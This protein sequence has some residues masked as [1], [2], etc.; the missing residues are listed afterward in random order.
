MKAIKSFVLVALLVCFGLLACSCSAKGG[1]GYDGYAPGGAYGDYEGVP[2]AGDGTV[3]EPNGGLP[4]GSMTAGAWNDNDNYDLWKQLF[5]QGQTEEE[6]GKFNGISQRYGFDNSERVSVT[7]KNGEEPVAGA[8]VACTDGQGSVVFHAVTDANGVAYLF[9]GV[10]EGTVTVTSGQSQTTAQFTEENRDI[11][12]SVDTSVV[13]L[14]VIE[15]MFVVD[16]TGSM[17][18]EITYLKTELA[19]VINRVVAANEQVQINLAFL[20]Y[21]DHSDNEVFSYYDFVDVSNAEGLAYQQKKLSA[22]RA[23]GGG[24]YPEA[25]DEALMQAVE[26]NWS[27]KAT[28]KIIF[29]ILDAPI[30]GK[31]ANVDRYSAAVA[32]GAKK[33]IRIC[34]VLAS[35]ASLETEYIS[36][37][38]AIRTGGTFVFI[39][40][41]SGIGGG[42]HDPELPN[43][44]VE[45]LNSLMVRLVNGYYTGEFADPVDWRQE[46][47]G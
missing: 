20:F 29:N 34:P 33:G 45:A 4:A 47:R 31:K 17:G 32:L 9:P 42:H 10:D 43:V 8:S 39:T 27:D 40:D 5:W 12:V 28:T 44:T 2:S 36:R 14:N 37:Q 26:K 23:S 7:V 13:K 35:G 22:Q 11:S 24:D 6:N 46:V 3:E 19:D 18:D 41:D 30:H 21:R 15:L 16:V 25:L 1:L 38:A